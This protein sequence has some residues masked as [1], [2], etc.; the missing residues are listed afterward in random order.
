MLVLSV[1]TISVSCRTTPHKEEVDES[2]KVALVALMPEPPTLP[3]F[4]KLG[5]V[6]EDGKYCLSEADVDK[7]L[8]HVE[9]ELETFKIRLQI[10]DTEVRR[11]VDAL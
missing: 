11:I 5:W 9:T 6:Y 2:I 7:L 3:T 1:S 4:P 8:F 10:Y